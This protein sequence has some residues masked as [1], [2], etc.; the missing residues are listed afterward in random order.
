MRVWITI[1]QSGHGFLP[2]NCRMRNASTFNLAITWGGV[3]WL[4]F[5]VSCDI[6]TNCGEMVLFFCT[7]SSVPIYLV[8]MD[9]RNVL[10]IGV[11]FTLWVQEAVMHILLL[12]RLFPQACQ[13]KCTR[14]NGGHMDVLHVCLMFESLHRCCLLSLSANLFAYV[15]VIPRSV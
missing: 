6:I 8:H 14:G 1:A 9:G 3:A 13:S 7:V 4:L 12:P 10:I 2:T 11:S 15:H 5:F